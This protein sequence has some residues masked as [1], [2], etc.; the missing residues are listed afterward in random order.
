MKN[1]KCRLCNA[2]IKDGVHACFYQK[3]RTNTKKEQQAKE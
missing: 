3:K 2:T 1:E